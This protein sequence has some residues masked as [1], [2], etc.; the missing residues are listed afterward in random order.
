MPGKLKKE[1]QN[2]VHVCVWESER[3]VAKIGDVGVIKKVIVKI[4]SNL[5]K[6]SQQNQ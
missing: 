2:Y 5:H 6:E 4:G 1:L 3:K